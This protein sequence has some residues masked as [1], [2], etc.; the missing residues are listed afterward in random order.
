[1]RGL[2]KSFKAPR[3]VQKQETTFRHRKEKDGSLWG[4]TMEKQLVKM[5]KSRQSSCQD[6]KDGETDSDEDSVPLVQVLKSQ[7]ETVEA[8]QKRALEIE[9]KADAENLAEGGSTRTMEKERMA[10]MS[11]SQPINVLHNPNQNVFPTALQELCEIESDGGSFS[12]EP[13]GQ[14][15][16]KTPSGSDDEDVP[17]CQSN[18]QNKDTTRR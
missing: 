5:D 7:T 15:R 12:N 6:A 3:Q 17:I 2:K 18:D 8:R 1:M 16:H 13:I 14:S 10:G 4:K 9:R 11:H